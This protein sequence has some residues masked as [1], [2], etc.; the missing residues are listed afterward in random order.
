M[1]LFSDGG[2][3]RTASLVE[4]YLTMKS[5]LEEWKKELENARSDDEGRT[6]RRVAGEIGKYLKSDY[7]AQQFV[8]LVETFRVYAGKWQ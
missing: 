1:G 5:T 8:K 6:A 2:S 4:A 3:T 7:G